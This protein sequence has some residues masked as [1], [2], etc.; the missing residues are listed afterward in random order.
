MTQIDDGANSSYNGLLAA[1][2]HRMSNNF[3]FLANYT[4]SHCISIGDSPGDVT[5]PTYENSANK[6]LDRANCGFDVRHI[7]N[8]TFV[9]STHFSSLHGVAGAFANNWQLAPIIRITSGTPLNVTSGIDNSLTGI[10]LD[11][12]NLV[13]PTGVYTRVKI[14]QKAAGNLAYISKAAFAQNAPGTYGNLGRNAFRGPNYYDVD[15]A[16]SRTFPIHERLDFNLR[17]EAFNV[18]NHPNFTT[19]TTALNSGTFGNATAANDPRIFQLA[20]KFTF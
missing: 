1:I 20:G 2:Q 5:A 14:T 6:K 4:W 16:L 15:A 8:T 12:P 18:L 3:S 17:I 10:G 11:R 7:F 13:N 19:F 9:A